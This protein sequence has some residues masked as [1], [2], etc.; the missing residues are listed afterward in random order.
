MQLW[1]P[2]GV[3]LF[4]GAGDVAHSPGELFNHGVKYGTGAGIR[5]ML[6]RKARVNVTADL[7][8]GN[9]QSGFYLDLGETF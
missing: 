2:L 3:V 1:W 7:A 5:V 9:D 6:D 4:A 8:W